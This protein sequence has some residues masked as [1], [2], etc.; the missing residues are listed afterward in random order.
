MTYSEDVIIAG[1]AANNSSRYGDYNHLVCDPDGVTFWF[2]CEYNVAG[3]WSTRITSFTLDA[4]TGSTCGDPTGLTSSS[5]TTTGATVAWSAVTGALNYDVDYKAST[6][7]TWINAATATSSLSANISGLNQGTLYDW[8]VRANCSSASGN[9]V[10]SQFTTTTSVVCSAPTG[11]AS[12]SVSTTSEN[13]SWS[14]VSGAASYDVDYEIPGSNNWINAATA[15]TSTS[16]TI[17]GL[18]A[19]TLYDWRVRSNCSGSSSSYAT[20]QFT[21]SS[22]VTGCPDQLEPNNTVGTAASISTNLDYN[23]TIAVSTDV[24]YYAFSTSGGQKNIKVTLTNLPVNF[25][26]QLLDGNG[27]VIGSSQ[28][29]GTTSESITWNTKKAGSYKIKVFSP[30]GSASSQCYTVRASTGSGAFSPAVPDVNVITQTYKGGLKVFPVP[31]STSI[32]VSFN[33]FGSG[34]SDIIITNQLGQQL[35]NKKINV[36]AGNNMTTMNISTLVSGVYFVKVYN[37][38]NVETQKMV[39]NSK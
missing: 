2:T 31:A 33:S 11:L 9:Y 39:V 7:A 16:A 23:A 12:S 37:G 8:R 4:C 26:I 13:V 15:T 3:T 17:N 19:G 38:K 24:D 5:I 6:S 20:A 34:I 18:T 14:A 1:T 25:D 22:V 30:D 27:N 32:T 21:T 10:A 35:M 36:F 29:T 28:N